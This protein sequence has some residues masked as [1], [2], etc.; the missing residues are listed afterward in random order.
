[1]HREVTHPLCVGIQFPIR[2]AK[3]VYRGASVGHSRSE[4]DILTKCERLR[5]LN[6]AMT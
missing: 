1:L 5:A 3:H 6:F 2:D 4:S